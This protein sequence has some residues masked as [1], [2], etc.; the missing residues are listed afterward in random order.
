[1]IIRFKDK[2]RLIDLFIVDQELFLIHI[3]HLVFPDP[4]R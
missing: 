4:Y 3:H 2:L 1:M